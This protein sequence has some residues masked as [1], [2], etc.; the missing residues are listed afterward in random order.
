MAAP[1]RGTLVTTGIGVGLIGVLVLQGSPEGGPALDPRSHAPDGTS[2]LVALLEELGTDVELSEGLPGPADDVALVLV[3]D[4]DEEQRE[5]VLAWVRTGGTLVVTDPRSSLTPEALPFDPSEGFVEETTLGPGFCSID[6]LAD[7]DE[8]D[9]GIAFRYDTGAA[10]SSC[11]G[12]RDFA[13]VVA[14]E[15]GD[16][17][18]VSV[19]GADLVTNAR[20][21][22]DD[23][24]V[25]A[26][27]LLAPASGATVRVVDAPIPAGGGDKTLVDL[28]SD[29]VRRAGLQLGVAFLLYAVWRAVRLG[30]PVAEPQA[31]EIAGSELVGAAGR[32]LER[33]RGAGAAAE[34]L[35]GRLRRTLTSRYGMPPDVPGATLVATVAERTGVDREQV[36]LAIGERPVS[37]DGELVSVTTAIAHVQQEVLR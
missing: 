13:F 34:V 23:N 33:G 29:G 1:S 2:A 15:E 35:R 6:A 12:S 4:L 14:E 10:A 8:V 27:A 26:A 3:D 37:S 11:L 18:V 25:L 5:D 20:L 32:L 28:I 30:R 24:A 36:E 7:V 19:G 16:G 17:T 22:H 31:V 9:A 21:G